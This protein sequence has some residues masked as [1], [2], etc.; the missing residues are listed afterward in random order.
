MFAIIALTVFLLGMVIIGF[1]GMKKTTSLNDF[2]LGGRSIGPWISSF[3]YGTTYF[4]AVIFIGFAG[5]I[6]WGFG[7][8]GMWIVLGNSIIGALLAW[9]VLGRRTRR[10]TQ[11]LDVMT[12]PEFLQ[13]RFQ[14]RYLKMISAVIIFVFLTPYSAS[15]FKG[16]G[17]LFEANFHIPYNL[18]LLIMIGI[19]GIYLIMGGYF[20]VT[21]TDFIQGLIM[22]VGSVVMVSILVGQGGGFSNVV[23]TISQNYPQHVPVD[24]QAPW[25]L[26]A[27]L[28][29]MTSFGAW[30]MPQMVQKFYAIKDEKLIYKA[31][32]VTTLFAI[33]ITFSAYFT[34]AMTHIFY[35][36][37]IMVDGK[38]VF[39]LMIP[40][41]LTKH[42]PAPVMV[43]ILLLVLSASMS[44]LS[45]LV[46]VSASAIAIDLY[47]GHVNPKVSK[48]NSLIMMR[49]LSG[50]FV[51]V[52][53]FIAR[54]KFE[55]IV[56]LMSIS[57]G[58][59]AGAFMAPFVY[60]LYWKRT[61]L[62]GVKSGMFAGVVLSVLLYF[63][64]GSKLSPLGAS[65]AILVPFIVVPLVS[66]FTKP[67]Q[68]NTIDK[69]FDKI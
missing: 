8:K 48:E 37:P 5:S 66:V 42:L 9:L 16:L 60:G 11:N 10:M 39:D 53:Y 61:T 57:W 26:L 36:K 32:V 33:I 38:P 49:F 29:F 17:H 34:G 56:T 19:T 22:L 59:V 14:G 35:D 64:L 25:F 1:W 46:L 18:A 15:V 6:G 31:A 12:M 58:A 21:L 51:V 43:I 69:S 4:S 13:E 23:A 54:T 67:P 3:A 7:L 65:I 50:L 30:G 55:V 68:K 47:K 44:T 27:G 52:S 28:V 2:F 20:A 63:K 45:S 62:A 40:D 24:K 41:L